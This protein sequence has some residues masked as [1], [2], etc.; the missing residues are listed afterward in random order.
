[1]K[2]SDVTTDALPPLSTRGPIV[3]WYSMSDVGSVIFIPPCNYHNL[4][5]N[6]TA[7]FASLFVVSFVWSVFTTLHRCLLKWA[8]DS[9]CSALHMVLFRRQPVCI[10]YAVMYVEASHTACPSPGSPNWRPVGSFIWSH[11]FSEPKNHIFFVV[12]VVNFHCWT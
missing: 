6:Q 3:Q 9:L 11:K 2:D 12:V 1:M 5:S 7:T 4:Y 10:W 8:P